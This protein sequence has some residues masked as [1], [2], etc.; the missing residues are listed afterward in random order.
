M[1]TGY[2]AELVARRNKLETVKMALEAW[3]AKKIED[4]KI[5]NEV[6]DEYDKLMADVDAGIRDFQGTATAIRKD[7]AIATCLIKNCTSTSM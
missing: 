4:A 2:Q 3:Y 7:P 5:I 1:R 6:K